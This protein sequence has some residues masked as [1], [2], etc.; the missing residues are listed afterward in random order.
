MCPK[1]LITF[2]N[3]SF[4]FKNFNLISLFY[5]PQNLTKTLTPNFK[6]ANS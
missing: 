2:K 4:T 3:W 5:M 6:Q 1:T